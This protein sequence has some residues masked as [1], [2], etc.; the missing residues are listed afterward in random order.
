MRSSLRSGVVSVAAL[1]AMILASSAS[2]GSPWRSALY[3]EDWVPGYRD[4]AGRFLH[5]FSYAGYHR[6]VLPLPPPDIAR[7][8][9]VD[10][11]DPPFLADNSGA[12]DATRA[13]NEA[14]QFVGKRG[15]GVVHLPAG[16]YRVRP[17]T[18]E[19]KAAL[20]ID[21]PGVV[22][23]GDGVDQTFIF[24][25]ETAMR[26]RNVIRMAPKPIRGEDFAWYRNVGEPS[27]P[28]TRDADELDTAVYVDGGDLAVGDWVLVRSDATEEFI[29][30]HYM[31]G[32]WTP[33]GLGGVIF[34]RQVVAAGFG[35][36]RVELDIPIR[37]PVKVRD[38][39][40]VTRTLPHI[41]EVAVENLS[42]GS[43]AITYGS[44]GDDDWEVPGTGA[45]EVH[46]SSL[47]EVNHVANGWVRNVSSY[48][49]D[50]NHDHHFLSNGIRIRFARSV[51]VDNVDLRHSQYHGSGGNGY[52]FS[53]QG[54]DS[55]FTSCFSRDARHNFNVALIVATGNV[56][57]E[58]TAMEGR[59]PV[60]FHMHL[61]PANLIDSMVTEDDSISAVRRDH[62]DHGH[63]T[64]QSVMWN[65]RGDTDGWEV[66]VGIKK[67]IK[68][69]QFRWG[70]VIGTS[71][72]DNAVDRPNHAISRP[73]DFVE[74]RGSGGD[75]IPQSL[76]EDQLQR[77]LSLIAP[78][79]SGG[80]R[81][82]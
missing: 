8:L 2:A 73:D 23:R 1:A 11:T 4:D 29:D 52:H 74:G 78:R 80:R 64:T 14:I 44:M 82:P 42:M 41:E 61:S 19:D 66:Q 24:N 56:I 79:N 13:I 20:Y 9:L 49:P 43:R 71:G 22:L 55:L 46:N 58:S 28:L 51:V 17:R 6:G 3:P 76:Y 67:L 15:G 12:S 69:A 37:Y 81:A 34:Y 27:F 5:D 75:L 39:A 38:N 35:D 47:I 63:G 33:S 10:V 31:T 25:D 18:P 53:I 32:T 68:T 62:A 65:T 7:G 48:R 54:S 70:Y 30:E 72:T 45:Y 60:E 26:S 40:R 59:M 77:R 21:L 57:H 36:G 16:T 50:E